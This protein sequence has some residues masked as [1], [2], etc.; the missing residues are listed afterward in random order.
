VSSTS[1]SPASGAPG[2]TKTSSG[3]CSWQSTYFPAPTPAARSASWSIKWSAIV[4]RYG[5]RWFRLWS[6]FLAWSILIA[7]QGSSAL[8]MLTLTK[9]LKNDRE[10][11]P[12]SANVRLNRRA[13]F[14]GP[15]P[16]ATQQ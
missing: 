3:A 12:R 8:F 9:N 5:Q 10:T 1:K 14:I 6:F 13:R 4:A 15:N 2:S 11:L 7:S 16:V